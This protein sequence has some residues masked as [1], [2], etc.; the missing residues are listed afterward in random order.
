M[1]NWGPPTPDG[2][3]LPPPGQL[4]P[5]GAAPDASEATPAWW[6]RRWLRV[7]VWGWLSGLVVIVAVGVLGDPESDDTTS[8]PSSPAATAPTA[9]PLPTTS[10]ST[11]PTTTAP[12]STAPLPTSAPRTTPP[13]PTTA[14]STTAPVPTTLAPVVGLA[15]SQLVAL[16]IAEP[17][18]TRPPYERDDYDRD[19]WGDFDGDCVS[20]RHELLITYSLDPPVIDDCQV[21]S[22][23]WIDP[24]DGTVY[25]D[26]GQVT[27]DHVIPLAEAHRAGAWRWD[28]D[29]RY[30]F[31]N[32]ETPGHLLVIGD[33]VQPVEG[34]QHP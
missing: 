33:A 31:T 25:T 24:Y 14:P 4:P 23:R 32:D 13:P 17:D 12:V 22:G 1:T 34:G 18:P 15:T 6:R 16:V 29:T 19:G 5:P 20:T 27:I 30:R 21:T 9:A 28:L 2:P 11:Q 26:A 7:P 8:A 3:A 10:A